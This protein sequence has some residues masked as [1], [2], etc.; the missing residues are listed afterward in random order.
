ME[1]EPS[2]YAGTY[3]HYNN[4]SLKGKWFNLEDYRDAEDFLAAVQEFHGPGEHEFMYQDFQDFPRAF[5][6][7]SHIDPVIWE[8]LA[9]DERD[10]EVVWA[11]LDD[12]D[13]D[14][15]CGLQ[16]ILDRFA[17]K[18]DSLEDWAHEYLDECG[19]LEKVPE[20]LRNYFNYRAWAED[21]RLEG[22]TDFATDFSP[23]NVY[24]FHT[25]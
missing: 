9:L 21:V 17:G 3:G 10:R 23:G 4:G 5:Y 19:G 24:V 25:N 6:S 15:S 2:I 1:F 20:N 11:Y 18:Y 22:G 16:A 8:W 12:I 7:E 14:Y 13:S